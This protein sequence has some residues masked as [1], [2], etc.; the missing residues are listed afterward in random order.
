MTDE[1]DMATAAAS[2][3]AEATVELLRFSREGEHSPEFAFE[4]EAVA[5]LADALKIALDIEAQRLPACI[6][7]FGDDREASE[8][9]NQL[10]GALT[11]FLEGWA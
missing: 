7:R 4:E 5:K 1:R 8:L 6:D 3:A 2:Q 10:Q 11:R 9:L